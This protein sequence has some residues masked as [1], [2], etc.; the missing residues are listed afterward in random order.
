[1][2][3]LTPDMHNEA[4]RFIAFLDVWYDLTLSL[5]LTRNPTL[6]LTLTRNPN[7]NPNST[8]DQVRP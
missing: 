2:P 8:P 6:T 7:P 5:T 3:Q 1:M 4:R